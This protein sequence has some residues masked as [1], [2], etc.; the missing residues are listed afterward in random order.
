[1]E[2]Y[3]W[4]NSQTA[5]TFSVAICSLGLATVWGG[6]NLAKM[7]PRKIA[8]TGGFLFGAGYLLGASALYFRSLVSLYLGYGLIGGMG[9]GLGYVTPVATVAKW[10]P[11]KKGFVTGMVIM[12]FGLGALLMSKVFAPWLVARTNG[13]MVQVFAYLGLLFMITTMFAASFLK[14]PPSGYVPPGWAPPVPASQRDSRTAG[15]TDPSAKNCLL[16]GRFVMTWLVLFCNVAAGIAIIAF[17]SPLLQDLV[18]QANPTLADGSAVSKALLATYGGWLIAV[19]SLF[20]GIGRFFW[21]GL[22]DRIGRAQVFRIMFASQVVVFLALVWV[23]NPWIFSLLICY[24]LLCYGGGFGTMPSFVS[25]VFGAKLMPVVYGVVLTAWSAAGVVGPQIVAVFKDR[26]KDNASLYSF[27]AS[28]GLLAVG[29]AFSLILSNQRFAVRASSSPSVRA[30][31][32]DEA[33]A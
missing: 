7:G 14:N 20:N 4:N 12:G 1:M 21:G 2:G 10:F 30:T 3:G 24:V 29:L 13:D 32:K 33:E 28:A 11:D 23:G 27:L 18:K 19:S 8:T 25:D 16:S 5:W 6:M 17:Q 9:L 22:S 31:A 15:E 26:F